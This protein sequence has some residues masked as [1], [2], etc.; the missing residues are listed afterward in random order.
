MATGLPAELD[1]LVLSALD[2]FAYQSLSRTCYGWRQASQDDLALKR[3]IASL[4]LNK[5]DGVDEI[6]RAELSP[7][8]TSAADSLMLNARLQAHDTTTT[9][10]AGGRETKVAYS[11]DLGR[12]V[13]LNARILTLYQDS[14]DEEHGRAI[15][16]QALLND[17]RSK[18]RH[19]PVL[20]NAPSCVFEIALAEHS[21]LVAVALDRIIQVYDLDQPTDV[22][23][24]SFIGAAAGHFITGINFEKDDSLLRITLS[25]KGVVLYLGSSEAT[26]SSSELD[27]WKS[28][29]GLDNVYLNSTKL[30]LPGQTGHRL[31]CLQLLTETPAGQFWTAQLHSN[32]GPLGYVVGRLPISAAGTTDGLQAAEIIAH[33]AST[34]PHADRN[35][36][37]W[38]TAP[39]N[40]EQSKPQYRLTHD[41][42]FLVVIEEGK[43]HF[44]P[45]PTGNRLFVWKMPSRG[46]ETDVVARLPLYIGEVP[47]TVVSCSVTT[48][49][50]Q[51]MSITVQTSLVKKVF[52]LDGL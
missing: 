5:I 48:E 21:N 11:P 43:S 37:F 29:S 9:S 38:A 14:S 25:N 33:L 44:T 50:C 17:V 10:M 18:S 31:A 20:R 12:H 7:T 27:Y 13:S 28:S 36:H 34:H 46:G 6:D 39:Q 52:A 42:R 32:A 51:A 41:G 1:L 15:L 4:P 45:A 22:P 26:N 30:V 23:A 8:W 35:N 3:Q 49:S 19:G 24:A 2:P 40:K 47:G 16:G